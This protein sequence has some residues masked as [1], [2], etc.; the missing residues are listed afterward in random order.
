MKTNWLR[1]KKQFLAYMSKEKLMKLEYRDD[2]KYNQL[3]PSSKVIKEVPYSQ[4]NPDMKQGVTATSI[5]NATEEKT[6]DERQKKIDM[7][8]QSLTKPMARPQERRGS[9]AVSLTQ[10]NML[11]E[12]NRFKHKQSLLQRVDSV[13]KA[14]AKMDPNNSMRRLSITP[15][16]LVSYNSLFSLG[17]IRHAQEDRKINVTMAEDDCAKGSKPG[18]L[19]SSTITDLRKLMMRNDISNLMGESQDANPEDQNN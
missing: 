7:L 18:D 6:R 4:N 8:K 10:N 15:Q 9:V 2:Q 12:I 16:N 11:S 17:N 3:E 13:Q 5:S 1:M 19:A 14:P